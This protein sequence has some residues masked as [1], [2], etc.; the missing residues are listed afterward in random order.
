MQPRLDEIRKQSVERFT[1][2]RGQHDQ[3][4]VTS[5]DDVVRAA[6]RGQVD[7]LLLRMDATVWGNYDVATDEITTTESATATSEDLF[8][9]AGLLTVEYGGSVHILSPT[10]LP[11]LTYGAATLRF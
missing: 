2:L 11:D 4:A 7:T 10:D 3:R 1:A 8:E 9:K 6:Y 5:V